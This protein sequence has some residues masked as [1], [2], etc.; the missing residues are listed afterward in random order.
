MNSSILQELRHTF[1]SSK[2]TGRVLSWIG[3][4]PSLVYA[5][6][7]YV[8]LLATEEDF[9]SDGAHGVESLYAFCALASLSTLMGLDDDSSPPD[10]ASDYQG[11]LDSEVLSALWEYKRISPLFE[12]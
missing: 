12:A 5:G 10:V 7:R 6:P 1:L 4:S 8:W 2:E 9:Y 11:L 3:N